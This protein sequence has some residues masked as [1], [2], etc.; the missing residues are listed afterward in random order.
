M[1]LP[2]IFLC[3]SAL[4]IC[5]CSLHG[6]WSVQGEWLYFTPSYDETYYVIVGS[7]E[8][9]AGHLVPSGRRMNNP[10]GYNSGFRLD[11][12]CGFC[13]CVD[14]KVRWTHLYAT[15]GQ[16]VANNQLWPIEIIPSQPNVSQPYAGQASS[17]IGVMYQKGEC[18]FDERAWCFCLG[19]LSFREGIEWSYIRYHEV[20]NYIESAGPQEQR[21]LHAHTKG[22]GP[23]L[24]ILAVLEP[25]NVFHWHPQC[26]S[27]CLTTTG[28][29][30]AANAK[31]KVSVTNTAS[32]RT[33]VTQ[34][35]FWR[36]VPEWVVRFGIQY[37]QEFR[38][39]RPSLE[40]GY[41]LTTY[42]R[43]ISKLLFTDGANPGV[44]HN[45]YSDFYV[46][47]FFLGLHVDF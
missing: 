36:I 7:Q 16:S 18:L 27:Y 1:A 23:Q 35:S 34:Q 14:F 30:I 15:S 22:V 38:C 9:G 12:T 44:S 26:L 42:V 46:H 29:L 37:A 20:V 39:C 43:G 41:E 4:F 5:Q 25:S 10:I 6:N 31:S 3:L 8:D 24:G 33:K 2:R 17:H 13:Q 21:R 40:C 47:G 32:V 19:A 28:T 11:G 45:Q